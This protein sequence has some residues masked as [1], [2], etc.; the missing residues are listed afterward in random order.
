MNPFIHF[1]FVMLVSGFGFISKADNR[2]IDWAADHIRNWQPSCAVFHKEIVSQLDRN[3]DF[4]DPANPAYRRVRPEAYCKLVLT[5]T[6]AQRAP[7]LRVT[8]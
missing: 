8:L 6:R 5:P 3:R 4:T 7:F 1:L 2:E